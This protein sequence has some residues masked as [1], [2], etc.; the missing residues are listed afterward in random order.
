MKKIFLTLMSLL[1]VACSSSTVTT[2]P[3]TTSSETAM[4]STSTGC[5]VD[6]CESAEEEIKN[7]EELIRTDT[8]IEMSMA[9]SLK[10]IEA[11]ESLIIYYG[12][13]TCPWCQDAID[14]IKEAAD[15]VGVKVN[16]VN[17][18]VDG[19][20]SEFDLRNENNADYV[21]LQEIF[22][23]T[24]L[25]DTKKIYVPFVVTVKTGEVLEYHYATVE[26]HDAKEREMNEDEIK[27]LLDIYTTMFENF[28]NS[29]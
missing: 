6:E 1:L 18:R 20:T 27:Q 8:F 10:A 28:K 24:L 29:Q 5:A 17:T 21:K 12:F 26:N 4:P 15:N 2:T 23:D 14:Y 7:Y 19:D 3:E 11:D 13:K 9:D 16:Y 22:K 25:D